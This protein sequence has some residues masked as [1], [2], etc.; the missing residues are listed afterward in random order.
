MELLGLGIFVLAVGIGYPVQAE[1]TYIGDKCAGGSGTKIVGND[2]ALYCRSKVSM[3][4]WSAFAWC[5]AAD[6]KLMSLDRCNGKNGDIVNDADCPNFKGKNTGVSWTSSVPNT[7]GAY[8]IDSGNVSQ[9][10]RNSSFP[11]LCE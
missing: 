11:A 2:G 4:W 5:D 6:G 1:I 9:A 8:Y 3:H 7:S 10:F